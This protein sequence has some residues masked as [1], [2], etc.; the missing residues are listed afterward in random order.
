MYIYIYSV[1]TNIYILHTYS[2]YE[3]TV[4][5]QYTEFFTASE[6]NKSQMF[7]PALRFILRYIKQNNF[8]RASITAAVGFCS[9]C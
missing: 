7:S 5:L 2:Q 8:I 3:Y 6:K 9:P 4:H 1:Y